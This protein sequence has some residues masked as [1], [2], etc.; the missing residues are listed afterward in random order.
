M[1]CIRI[2]KTRE[3]AELAKKI[4]QEGYT[5]GIRFKDRDWSKLPSGKFYN[6]VSELKNIEGK[7]ILIFHA[8]DDKAVDWRPVAKFATA[9]GCKFKL[10]KKGGHFGTSDG[11][12]MAIYKQIKAFLRD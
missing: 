9:A 1:I 7:K 5:W 10:Y 11:Q 8:K 4:L 6:P 12:K 3:E 2:F